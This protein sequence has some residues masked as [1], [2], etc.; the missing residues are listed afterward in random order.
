MIDCATA[1]AF[2]TSVVLFVKLIAA[3]SADCSMNG[4]ILADALHCDFHV[5]APAVLNSSD[6]DGGSVPLVLS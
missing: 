3:E 4:T 6:I 5:T 1:V 2:E